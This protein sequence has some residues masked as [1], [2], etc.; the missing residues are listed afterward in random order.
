MKNMIS[1]TDS[2]TR[3]IKIGSLLKE[4]PGVTNE[5]QKKQFESQKF[6]SGVYKLNEIYIDFDTNSLTDS[7]GRNIRIEPLIMDLLAYMMKNTGSY[8]SVSDLMQHVWS[9]RIVSDNAVRVAVKKLRDAMG[10]NPK[11]PRFIK[12]SPNR[13]YTI[14]AQPIEIK[15]NKFYSLS[16][17]RKIR[18]SN[19]GRFVSTFIFR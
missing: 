10:D 13:G 16:I 2:F 11:L 18:T 15:R 19:I 14:I 1:N 8:L 9:G 6:R 5:E 7:Y 3:D 12:T 17:K 4:Q